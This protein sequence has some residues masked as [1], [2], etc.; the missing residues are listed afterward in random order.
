MMC[1][2]HV[3]SKINRYLVICT[4]ESKADRHDACNITPFFCHYLL[5]AVCLNHIDT[6]GHLD[7]VGPL[8]GISSMNARNRVHVAGLRDDVNP[9]L[10][11]AYSRAH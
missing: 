2:S 9:L 6:M 11:G 3:A 1:Q 8:L 10:F 4:G 5:K 7:S